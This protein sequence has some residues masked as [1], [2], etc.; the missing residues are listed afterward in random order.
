MDRERGVN[1]R[2]DSGLCEFAAKDL[3]L[4]DARNEEVVD[5][6]PASSLDRKLDFNVA[7]GSAVT[8]SE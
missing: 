2:F 7:Q 1:E 6:L 5:V 3:A 8:R 4:A